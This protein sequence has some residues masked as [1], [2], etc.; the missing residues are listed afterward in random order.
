MTD[1]MRAIAQE[2]RGVISVSQVV[3]SIGWRALPV[4]ATIR[5]QEPEAGFGERP[6]RVPLLD[7]GGQGTMDEH[8]RYSRADGVDGQLGH[9]VTLRRRGREPLRTCM[10]AHSRNGAAS[11]ATGAPAPIDGNGPSRSGSGA[12]DRSPGVTRNAESGPCERIV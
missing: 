10:P 7:A 4:P 6:L 2:L 9:E 3:F 8:D 1:E 11:D 12:T 5:D